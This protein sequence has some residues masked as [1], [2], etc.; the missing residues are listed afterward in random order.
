MKKY[1]NLKVMNQLSKL[2]SSLSESETIA[3]TRKSNELRA[4]G[5][6]VI[7]MSLGEPDFSTPEHIKDAARKAIDDN[8]THY[9]PVA[10]F[11]ELRDSIVKKFKRENNLTYKPE[12]IMVSNGA[13][14]SITNILLALLNPGDEVILPAPYWV[15]YREMVKLAGGVNKIIKTDIQHDFKISPEQLERSITSKTKILILNSPSNPS[16]S[17]YS[18]DE[19]RALAEVIKRH[20]N[21]FVISDEVYEHILYEGKHFS[22]AQI[23]DIKEQVIVVNSVSKSFAMTGWRIGYMAGPEWLIKACTNLQGQVTS[24]ANSIAQMAATAALN[25]PDDDTVRM[26]NIF[27][28]RRDILVTAFE[29]INGMKVMNP[30]GA[31]YLFPDVSRLFNK[32]FNGRT[33]KNSEDLS[34]YL[35]DE[36]H[37][38]TVPGS[39]FGSPE[40]IRLSYATSDENIKKAV[41]RIKRALS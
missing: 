23:N 41:E 27:R 28:K 35:L 14:H 33:V 34:W 20:R 22:M 19:L 36:A 11:P 7:S 21:L 37:V 40:C 26:K 29:R 4:K 13:K 15:S 39:A 5:T 10:G 12:N 1:T 3:M 30:L 18:E 38:A 17:V 32:T 6:D 31:F 9:A 16:G 2:I 24:G 8:I 25:G